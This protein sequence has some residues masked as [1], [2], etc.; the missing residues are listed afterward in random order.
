VTLAPEQEVYLGLPAKRRHLS[1]ATEEL[2]LPND[3]GCGARLGE[4]GYDRGDRGVDL[5]P[6]GQR[7]RVGPVEFA[8][9]L[10]ERRAVLLGL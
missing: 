1:V 7:V 4:G 5:D 6:G 10:V 3:R 2:F 9:G 8:C